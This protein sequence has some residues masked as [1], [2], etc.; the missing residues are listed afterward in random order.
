MLA[1]AVEFLHGTYRGSSDDLAISGIAPTAEWPPSPAR[2]FAAFVAADGTRDRCR[3]TDG[4]ELRFLERQ[5]PPVIYADPREQVAESPGLERF[6]VR[7]EIHKNTVQDYP[8]RLNALAREGGRVEPRSPKVVYVWETA[9][10]SEEVRG[11]LARRAARIGYLGCADSPVRVTVGDRL[12]DDHPSERWVPD[13]EGGATMPVP[14]DG[15]VD[16]LDRIYDD[17][18]TKP[19]S[20]LWA[21]RRS[22][23]RTEWRRYR[24]PGEAPATWT[25]PGKVLWLR[26]DGSIPGRRL[27][28]VTETLRAAVMDLYQRHVAGPGGALPGV[29]TGHGL[30][31]RGFEHAAWLGLPDVGFRWSRGNLHGAAVVL[32]DAT[33]P[34][35]LHG[36]R[37]C[38]ARLDRLVR[39][40]RFD[41]AVE[42]HADHREPWAAHPDRW[43]RPARRFASA[44][45]VVHERFVRPHPTLS[46]VAA[47]CRHAGLPEPVSMRLS[48]RPLLTG[49]PSLHPAEVRRRGDDRRPFSHLEVEFDRPVVGPVAVGAGRRF[50]LGLLVP[51][52]ET[53]GGTS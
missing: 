41:V 35:V 30:D 49:A 7:N 5:P 2:L 45:P 44:F 19:I 15:L 1:V 48:R 12:P 8:G 37:A 50:G 26:F 23:Y 14:F 34:E 16:V 10:P 40:G 53:E 51:L 27:L 28:A 47:W 42:P 18:V 13:D 25:V 17:F 20:G 9:E 43:R 24:E 46:D 3:W 4:S 33:P 39:P 52:P 6:V 38:L 31:G 11:A 36:V 21:P 22:A 29:L 32:P